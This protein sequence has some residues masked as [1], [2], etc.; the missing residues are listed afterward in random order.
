MP[1]PRTPAPGIDTSGAARGF[2]HSA[3]ATQLFALVGYEVE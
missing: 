2:E 3:S 1:L